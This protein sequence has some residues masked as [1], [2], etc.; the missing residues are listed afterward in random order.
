MAKLNSHLR[1]L[2]DKQIKKHSI[3]LT[4]DYL[5]FCNFDSL[6]FFIDA[7]HF[8]VLI[9]SQVDAIKKFNFVSIANAE[10]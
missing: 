6:L 3:G 2:I 7:Y 9:I 10:P 4:P 8:H 5:K 1:I